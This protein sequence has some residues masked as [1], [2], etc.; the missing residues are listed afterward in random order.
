M[1]PIHDNSSFVSSE[2]VTEAY[3]KAIGLIDE[4]VAPFLGRATTRALVQGAA[5]RIKQKYPFLRCLINRPYTDLKLSTIK[6]ECAGVAAPKLIEG[7][8]ALVDECF[9]GL[10]ELTGDLIA[11]PLHEEVMHQLDHVD[12]PPLQ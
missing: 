6:D 11:P 8:N 4:R 5:N 3:L 1:L 7:L 12:Q 9:A 10:R 2:Q